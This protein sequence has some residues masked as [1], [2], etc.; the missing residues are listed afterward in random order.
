[1]AFD[2]QYNKLGPTLRPTSTDATKTCARGWRRIN[3]HINHRRVTYP[4][5]IHFRRF[6]WLISHLKRRGAQ[7]RLVLRIRLESYY[8]CAM[9]H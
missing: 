3:G 9:D 7:W 2:I 1:V 8:T 6:H 5:A 4:R